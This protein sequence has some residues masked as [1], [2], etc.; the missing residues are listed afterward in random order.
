MEI[1]EGIILL[2]IGCIA[3]FLNVIAGGGSMLTVPAMIFMGMPGPV[4]NGTNRIAIIPQCFIAVMTFFKK[5]FSDFK[6][7]I[8]L[9]LCA[10]PG[11]VIGALIGSRLE[12]IWFNR[13]L[14]IIM[15]AV[16][17]I[18]A[19]EKKTKQT[20]SSE[21]QPK[22]IVLGHF[23]MVLV[24]CYG[25]F[26]QIGVGFILMPIL[27]RVMGLD[28]V[29]VNMHK[30]FIIMV[31]TIVALMVFA[32]QIQIYWIMGLFLAVGNSIGGWVGA[33]MSISK[34]ESMIRKVLNCV[35]VAMIVK[36]LFFP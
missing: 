26:I 28:L 18:M 23:L 6:L 8:T 22:N 32:S 17:I 30:V 20:V 10:I 4:A 19:T 3:G 14:A 24:G 9:S 31:Y 2:F 1:Y 36:L 5:G 29:R 15:I 33:S 7:S 11:A 16:M 27:S 21:S 34:G 12:G 25:G 35:L 13:V